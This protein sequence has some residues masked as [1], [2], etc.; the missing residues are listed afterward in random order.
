MSAQQQLD[1]GE[2][3]ETPAREDACAGLRLSYSRRESLDQ[4]T[5]RYFFQ[6]YGSALENSELQAKVQFLKGVKNRHLRTG[7]L[8]HLVIGT[9]FKKLKQG[10]QA[11]ADGLTKWA[12]ELFRQDQ[13]YS[14]HIRNG[15][16][17]ASQPFPPVVLDEILNERTGQDR[18]LVRAEEQLLN[19]L[20]QFFKSSAFSDFRVLGAS[21][22]SQI[23]RKF[24][25]GGFPGP[26]SGKVDLAAPSEHGATVVDWKIGSASDGGAESLQL[27]MY[28]M[29]AMKEFGVSGENV[30][31][32]KAHLISEEVVEF[33]ADQ[34]AFANARV[35]IL[36]DFERMGILHG[37]GKAGAIGA[38]TPNPQQGVC[39][40]C[41]FRKI[42]PEGQ[43]VVDD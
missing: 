23:E 15:G 34:H 5:R 11:F 17:A 20:E 2:V 42:C 25:L 27:A 43:A 19:S 30:R 29:W 35:R 24:S 9:Y 1:F 12:K 8:V 7:E 4:C 41:P 37:Y 39:R 21:A 16:R 31:I 28:G 3:P 6:Y 26:V 36:Q 32:A 38:F 10:K 18:L 33:K 14:V 22:G 13:V 40:L